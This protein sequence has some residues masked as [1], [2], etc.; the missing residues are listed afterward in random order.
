V[1]VGAVHPQPAAGAASLTYE[2]ATAG[3]VTIEIYG[4]TGER[5][6]EVYDGEVAAGRQSV[7]LPGERL[8]SGAYTVIVRTSDGMASV[9]F[10]IKR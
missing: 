7:D 4:V 3:R 2:V 8:T 9:P 5:V 10:V 1:V 6:A